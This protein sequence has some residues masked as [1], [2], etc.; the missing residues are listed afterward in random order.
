MAS[1]VSSPV[2]PRAERNRGAFF[3]RTDA[4]GAQIFVEE[5]FELVVGGH[6][7]ALAAFFVEAHP[8]ALAVEG[9]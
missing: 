7:V 4:G 3:I 5:G 1:P 8:P 6:F 9:F 2:R